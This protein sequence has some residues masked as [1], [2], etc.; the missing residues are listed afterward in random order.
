MNFIIQPWLSL[1][2]C[3]YFLDVGSI[4]IRYFVLHTKLKYHICCRS[5]LKFMTLA[6]DNATLYGKGV[7][8][9]GGEVV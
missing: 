8:R 2:P 6:T 1:G 4:L 7:T 5:Q 3:F 9:N